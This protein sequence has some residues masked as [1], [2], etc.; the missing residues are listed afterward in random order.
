MSRYRIF[1]LA[2]PL[3][4]IAVGVLRAEL[5]HTGG[6]V[7]TLEVRGVDP[8]DLLRGR[9]LRIRLLYE[10]EDATDADCLCLRRGTGGDPDTA[11]A[12][13][14]GA[15]RQVCA[16]VVQR[17]AV[18]EIRRYFLPEELAKPAE[19][20]FREGSATATVRVDA[21]QPQL[22]QL[23]VDGREVEDVARERP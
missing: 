12:L 21:E 14:C 11:T 7:W 4:L 18:D 23:F 1:A 19:D 9:F 16:G 5:S 15:A 6:E 3:V 13:E 8:R 10:D 2:L 17:D 20:A 22:L